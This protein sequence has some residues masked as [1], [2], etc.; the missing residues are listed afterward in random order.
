MLKNFAIQPSFLIFLSDI[1]NVADRHDYCSVTNCIESTAVLQFLSGYI[2]R[3]KWNNATAFV[4]YRFLHPWYSSVSYIVRGCMAYL[5]LHIP[6]LVNVEQIRHLASVEINNTSSQNC[7]V[8]FFYIVELPRYPL[9]T[10][11]NLRHPVQHS[12]Q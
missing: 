12:V 4:S 11:I 5:Y 3:S 10:T 6:T 2:E 1:E 9:R 7:E 8:S